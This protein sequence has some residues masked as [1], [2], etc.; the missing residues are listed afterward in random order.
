MIGIIATDDVSPLQIKHWEK[1]WDRLKKE[2]PKLK[3]LAFCVPNWHNECDIKDSKEFKEW[4]E[5]HK[6]WVTIGIHG[7]DHIL[8]TLPTENHRSKEEQRELI[9]KAIETLKEYLPEEWAYRCPANR[10]NKYTLEVLKELGCT[11][12][13]YL[14]VLINLK[15]GGRE[16]IFQSHTNILEYNRDDIKLFYNRLN[17]LLK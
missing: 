5:K 15:T 8:S 11:Y 6:E 9:K 16:R 12:F 2:N 3:V 13:T 7:Y 1:Y 14:N 10:F 17:R 4:F